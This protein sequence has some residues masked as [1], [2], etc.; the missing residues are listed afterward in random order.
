MFVSPIANY[1][2]SKSNFKSN[3]CQTNPNLELQKDSVSF[4]ARFTIKR[5][6]EIFQLEDFIDSIF[7]I[8]KGETLSSLQVNKINEIRKLLMNTIKPYL[9]D[10]EEIEIFAGDEQLLPCITYNTE[11]DALHVNYGVGEEKLSEAGTIYKLDIIKGKAK[12]IQRTIYSDYYEY[13]YGRQFNEKGICTDILN[14][15]GM[16]VAG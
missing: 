11:T 1:S 7:K 10:N 4:K 12:N 15:S 2:Y 13:V 6:P 8:N 16:K 14:Y 5:M 9:K 3:N